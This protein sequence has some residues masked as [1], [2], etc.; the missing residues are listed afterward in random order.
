MEKNWKIL[1]APP[2]ED[3]DGLAKAININPYL[4]TLLIQRGIADYSLALK[5]FRMSLDHLHDPFL[6]QDMNIAVERLA[7]AIDSEEKILIYGDYDVDGTTSV[8]MMVSY[9]KEHTTH[10]DFYIPDRYSEGYGVSEDGIN[11]AV[12]HKINLIIS[13][14]C[15]IKAHKMVDLAASNNIDFIVCDHH[16]PDKVLPAAT[17]VLDPKRKD[18]DYPYEELSGCGVGFKLLQGLTKHKNWDDADL[19]PLL[20]LVA[21]SIAADIVPITGENRVLCFFGLKILNK[22]PRSGLAALIEVG[23]LQKPLTVTRTVFGIAP[24]INA[25]GRIAHAHGAVDLMLSR[26]YE[27]ALYLAGQVNSKNEI[28][29]ETELEIVNEAIEMIDAQTIVKNTTVLYKEDWHK[30]VIGIVAS[31][32][33]EHFHR[34]TI[35][36][37]QSNGKAT[38]SARSVK[39]FD[40]HEA[41]GACSELLEQFGGH[42]YAAGLTMKQENVEPF[43]LMFEQVVSATILEEQL[44]PTITIDEEIDLSIISASYLSIIDQMEPFG[45]GNLKPVFISRNLKASKSKLL[46]ELHLKTSVF[47]EEDGVVI[48]AIGFNMPE[49]YEKLRSDPYFDMA[50]TIE[51]NNFRGRT[52]IQLHIK[53]IKFL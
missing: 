44:T 16:T 33:I 38:G 35:I 24:R 28:R 14:D 51:E 46:K 27:E 8:T 22:T 48:D 1:K 17:A 9:L 23:N 5:F 21:V 4:A 19:W 30:G 36:L 13:L 37:T 53:D 3:V 11:W 32:C 25:A 31:K 50:Y 49:Y 2:S 43:Q 52:T 15:G 40:I 26:D 6:M 20:D 39:G 47:N 12:E 34:P 18:C 10:I 41:I 29:K 45:P 42:K 7:K